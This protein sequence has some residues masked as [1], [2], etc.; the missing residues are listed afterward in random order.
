MEPIFIN[1]G[2]DT[3]SSQYNNYLSYEGKATLKI[4]I[5]SS[6][7]FIN[8]P[9]NAA[10]CPLSEVYYVKHVMFQTQKDH[11]RPQ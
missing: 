3:K 8:T 10:H 6:S 11:F 4:H 2:L 9:K 5:E 1:N 7:V